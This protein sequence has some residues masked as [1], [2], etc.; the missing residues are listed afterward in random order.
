MQ[1]EVVADATI[2][3]IVEL[4]ALPCFCG[5]ETIVDVGQFWAQLP[6]NAMWPVGWLLG[7][8]Q[9][10]STLV[11]LISRVSSKP[12]PWEAKAAVGDRAWDSLPFQ[13]KVF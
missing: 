8:C 7:C 4:Q 10:W 11:V 5:E 13:R 3:P 12:M 9:L 1:H 2:T 6:F